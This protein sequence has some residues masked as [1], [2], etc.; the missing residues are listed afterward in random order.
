[1]PQEYVEKDQSDDI[2]L[3]EMTWSMRRFSGIKPPLLQTMEEAGFWAYL[4]AL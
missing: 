1:V 2:S 4:I 3:R